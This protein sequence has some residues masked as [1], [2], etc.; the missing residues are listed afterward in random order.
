MGPE[1]DPLWLGQLA[2]AVLLFASA[3]A[4][5]LFD[6]TP[7]RRRVPLPRPGARR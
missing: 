1:L 5:L 7:Q 6:V 2:A 3:A 4:A